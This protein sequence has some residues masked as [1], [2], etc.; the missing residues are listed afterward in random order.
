MDENRIIETLSG[1]FEIS[2]NDNSRIIDLT[3]SEGNSILA[4]AVIKRKSLREFEV[5][6]NE[7]SLIM[8]FGERVANQRPIILITNVESEQQIYFAVLAY[9]DF[10]RY[11]YCKNLIWKRVNQKNVG[12]FRCFAKARRGNFRFLPNQ[13]FRIEKIISLNASS[14]FDGEIRYFRTFRNG[15]R[16]KK[17]EIQ[18]NDDQVNRYI[19]GTPEN[20]Y[21]RDRLDDMILKAV[22]EAY[23]GATMKSDLILFETD[24]LDLARLK[25]R[26]I[27]R[28]IVYAQN[29]DL[30]ILVPI[31]DIEILYT[32]NIWAKTE[33]IRNIMLKIDCKDEKGVND[34]LRELKSVYEPF[35]VMSI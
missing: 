31:T 2:R 22:Q 13:M 33:P 10:E 23:P 6:K 32:P 11:F 34:L 26:K 5:S 4:Y 29:N 7:L 8:D 17:T 35:S 25:D 28:E 18:S 30:N 14:L 20:A 16:M 21:P 24:L 19:Y 12:L 15:Y 9:W 1:Y 27:K 3:I